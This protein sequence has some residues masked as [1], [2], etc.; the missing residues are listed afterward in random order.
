VRAPTLKTR[1][2]VVD[3]RVSDLRAFRIWEF[4]IDEEGE[5]GQDETWVRPVSARIIP[6]D[7]Y[8][9]IASAEFCTA[10]GR[11]LQGF[12]I[13]TTANEQVQIRAGAVMGRIRYRA[14]PR[15]SRK[16]AVRKKATWDVGLRDKLLAAL[17]SHERDV[18]P[19]QYSL[20]VLIRGERSLRT[21]QLS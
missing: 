8:S 2:P 17:D 9:Q 18:F 6:K 20:R 16:M 4:A 19:L 7:A 11:K 10:T 3:L 1:K 13:V 15:L 12:M 5:T 21:G 14:L